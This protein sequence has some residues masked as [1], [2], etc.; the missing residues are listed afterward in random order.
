[1]NLELKTNNIL[2]RDYVKDF[3]LTPQDT[4]TVPQL[5][6]IHDKACPKPITKLKTTS[7]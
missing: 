6:K 4:P 1:M 3:L 5:M 2:L 7:N